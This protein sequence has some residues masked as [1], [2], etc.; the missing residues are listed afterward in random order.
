M[1]RVT[2]ASNRIEISREDVIKT[3]G[4]IDNSAIEIFID[5]I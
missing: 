3:Y 1:H 4:S 5:E 2:D